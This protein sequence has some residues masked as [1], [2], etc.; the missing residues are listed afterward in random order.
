MRF[1][2]VFIAL[3]IL[4]YGLSYLFLLMNIN[5]I[6]IIDTLIDVV[7]AFVFALLYYQG[8]K[9]EAFKDLNFHRSV[10]MYF[11]VLIIMSMLWWFVF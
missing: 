8:N 9:K 7:L 4:Q 6:Y 5:N 10:A 2:L 3:I 1:L 11:V